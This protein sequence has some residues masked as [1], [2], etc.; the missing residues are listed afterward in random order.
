MCACVCCRWYLQQLSTVDS[1]LHLVCIIRVM[2]IDDSS[3]HVLRARKSPIRQ[4]LSF[5]SAQ[6]RLRVRTTHFLL[7]CFRTWQTF[8]IPGSF[9]PRVFH[10]DLSL[11]FYCSFF[12][13]RVLRTQTR[14]LLRWSLCSGFL[15]GPTMLFSRLRD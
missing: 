4:T 11:G 1:H 12:C 14:L 8:V 9:K 10:S 2:C 6:R 15:G 5:S 13:V 7:R 3:R